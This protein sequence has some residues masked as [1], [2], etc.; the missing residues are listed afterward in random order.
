MSLC[1]QEKRKHREGPC[2]VQI[3]CRPTVTAEVSTETCLQHC[4][5][6]ND[7]PWL[8]CWSLPS[9]QSFL[10]GVSWE[11]MKPGPARVSGQTRT[12]I[13]QFCSCC[14]YLIHLSYK[15]CTVSLLASHSWKC[16]NVKFYL[17]ACVE[18]S[19]IF[20]LRFLLSNAQRAVVCISVSHDYV[21]ALRVYSN[22]S[23]INFIESE[24]TKHM[25]T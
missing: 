14:K 2:V 9:L 16:L 8:E 11:S 24:M 13:K 10:S 5:Q 20:L 21:K 19:D 23:N 22:S 25:R 1:R 12:Y 17:C 7:K 6:V 3:N 18:Q 15:T 4:L